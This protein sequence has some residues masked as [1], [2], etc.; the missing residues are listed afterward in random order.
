FGGELALRPLPRLDDVT[1]DAP[2]VRAPA[3]LAEI[4]TDAKLERV[5]HTY[6]RAYPDLVRGFGKDFR[7]APDLVLL[8]RDEDDVAA[9]LAFGA[10]QKVAIVPFGGG[11]S[12]VGGVECACPPG[13]R[14]V[15]SLD[16]RRMDKLLEL[17][18]TSRAARIQAGA[19]G[20]ALETQLAE[21]GFTL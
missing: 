2:R 14:G 3:R 4:A 11:T 21:R 6:G 15:A 8:P 20:P 5:L 7:P 16:L 10:E 19:K 9:C 13:M 18:E 17:D 1:L 12:V